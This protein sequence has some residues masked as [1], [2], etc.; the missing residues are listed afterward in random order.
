MFTHDTFIQ[1]AS[2]AIVR[3]INVNERAENRLSICRHELSLPPLHF[4]TRL[5]STAGRDPVLL[6]KNAY[7]CIYLL[8]Y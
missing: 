4:Y 6:V 2:I 7:V 1:I 8:S 5:Y 3:V